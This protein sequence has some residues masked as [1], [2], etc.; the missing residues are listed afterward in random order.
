MIA[1]VV[2]ILF[3]A[4]TIPALA[5]PSAQQCSLVGEWPWSIRA[6]AVPSGKVLRFDLLGPRDQLI[7]SQLVF[8]STDTVNTPL[9]SPEALFPSIDEYS[10]RVRCSIDNSTALTSSTHVDVGPQIALHSLYLGRGAITASFY[11]FQEDFF[12]GRE[13]EG[14]IEQLFSVRLDDRAPYQVQVTAKPGI[15][16]GVR[17]DNVG[18]GAHRLLFGEMERGGPRMNYYVTPLWVLEFVQ[19]NALAP[20][21]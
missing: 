11:V 13:D 4:S 5:S 6:T 21:K 10:P 2:G 16:I 14:L 12:A 20:A 18:A 15:D 19:P 9:L 7:G 1:A 8:D 3:V 17:F